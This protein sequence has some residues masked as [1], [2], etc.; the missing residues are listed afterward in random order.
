MVRSNGVAGNWEWWGFLLTGMTTVFI[1]AK[2]WRRTGV[3]TDVQYYELRYSGKPA[4]FLRGFR[5]GYMSLLFG[6]LSQAAITMAAI[7]IFGVLLGAAPWQVIV[8]G[9][10]I[11][12]TYASVGGLS[13]VLWTDFFQ[14]GVAMTGSIAAAVVALNHPKVGGLHAML[15]N[16]AVAK[17]LP[18][19][20]SFSNPDLVISIFV[21][22]LAVYWWATWYPG[23]EPGGGAYVA[24]RMLSAKNERHAMGAV[25]FFQF[26]HFALRPWPW[27]IVALCSVIVFPDLASMQMAFK[28]VK[29][30]QVQNDLAYSAML[31]FMPKGLMGIM[32]AS[33]VAAY[34]ATVSTKLNLVSSYVVNDLYGRFIRPQ[35]T[36]RELV[37]VGRISTVSWLCVSGYFATQLQSSLEVFTII[38]QIGAGTGLVFLLR[39]FWWRISAYSEIA[40][41]ATSFLAAVYFKFVHV[42]LGFQHLLKYQ[43]LLLG[44]AITTFVWL[45]VTML[46]PPTDEQCLR[47]FYTIVHPGGP[48]WRRLRESAAKDGEVLPDQQWDVPLGI[49]CILLGCLGIYSA[50]FATGNWIYGRPISASIL[51]VTTILAGALLLQLWGRLSTNDRSNCGEIV[52]SE[53]AV[54]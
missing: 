19:L 1:Y 29:T 7:K 28:H 6:I 21:M 25:L 23:S 49:I 3:M 48:G 10:G 12:A 30:S 42:H 54:V 17:L 38:I 51:S 18:M 9:G 39:W 22:P 37:R 15:N 2:L 53:K 46:T 11:T 24:Q 13:G 33:L 41:M 50:L 4:A 32:V 34:M 5:A 8:I 31:T 47:K 52:A 27:I 40:A 35:A 20:P 43:E 36:E 16:P 44:I 14:F 45:I 26:C